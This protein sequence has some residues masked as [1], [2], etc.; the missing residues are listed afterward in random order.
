MTSKK[1]LV[2]TF[3]VLILVAALYRVMPGRPFGFAPH[4][5]M[6][7]FAG[8]V[9]KDKRWAFAVP[10]ISMF[11]SD[12]FYHLL[13]VN[14][15]SPMQGFYSGQLTNYILFAGL[16]IVGFLIRR[17]TVMSVVLHSFTI[18]IAYFLISNFLVWASG[19]GYG[20]PQTFEGLVMCYADGLPFLKWNLISTLVFGAILFGGWKLAFGKKENTQ[21]ATH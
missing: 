17:V 13:Y 2:F 9:I 19:G 3:L 18:T 21:L 12:I 14:G 11:V 6:A 8:S 16:T 7:L 1:Q 20:R 5:A 4:L 10:V 15:L